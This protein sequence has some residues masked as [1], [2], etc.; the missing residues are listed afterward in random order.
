[1]PIKIDININ[2]NINETYNINNIIIFV[3]NFL[4]KNI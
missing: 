1:M 3:Y 2:F 4:N